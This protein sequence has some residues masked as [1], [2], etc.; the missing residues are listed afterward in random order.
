VA[1]ATASTT[2]S[3]FARD[4]SRDSLMHDFEIEI[5][6]D[7]RAHWTPNAALFNRFKKVWLLKILGEDLG[8]AQE[9]VTLASSSKKD[10]V[11]FCDKL[12][13]E[14]FATLSCAASPRRSVNASRGILRRCPNFRRHHSMPAIR[15]PD[16]SAPRHW[17]ATR[18]TITRCRSPMATATSGSGAM[19]ERWSSAAVA[20]S[21][22]VIHAAMIA[23]TWSSIRFTTF[24]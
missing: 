22:R 23:R 20:R 19:S 4:R 6:P 10:I 8:L 11:A 7:I 3:C 24:L 21:S 16:G 18:P 14:P 1:Y 13:A 5:M 2:Q 9:A 12:F 17:C 15:P